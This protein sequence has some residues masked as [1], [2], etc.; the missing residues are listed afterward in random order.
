[1][2]SIFYIY[3]HSIFYIQ[4]IAEIFAHFAFEDVVKSLR[5]NVCVPFCVTSRT[6]CKVVFSLIVFS[7]VP[8]DLPALSAVRHF[9]AFRKDVKQAKEPLGFA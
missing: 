8:K 9:S 7:F 4:Y 3:T 6:S 1:M 2:Y 5:R